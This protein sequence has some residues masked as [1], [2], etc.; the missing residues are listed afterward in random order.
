M[1]R[2][3]LLLHGRY[4]LLGAP[5]YHKKAL[6]E[7]EKAAPLGRHSPMEEELRF[8]VPLATS[9]RGLVQDTARAIIKNNS[10]DHYIV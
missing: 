7:I 2:Q 6:C 9:T 3:C 1:G 8:Q 5:L 10:G 4:D